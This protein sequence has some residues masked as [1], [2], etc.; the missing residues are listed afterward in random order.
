MALMVAGNALADGVMGVQVHS[1]L[2]NQMFLMAAQ[3]AYAKRLN[4]D[5][6]L[7]E[8]FNTAFRVPFRVCNAQ[9]KQ[10][11]ESHICY[12]D[13]FTPEIFDKKNCL[14]LDGGYYQDQRYFADQ[15]NIVRKIFGWANPLPDEIRG[16]ADEIQA[17]NSVSIHV[18]H[19]WDYVSIG[20]PVMSEKYYIHAV[21]YIR[22]KSEKP[23]HLYVFSDNMEWARKNLKFNYPTTFIEGNSDV[24]DMRLMSMCRHH[25][26]ANSTFSW[27]GAYLDP[28]PNKIVIAPDK[29]HHEMSWWGE[30]IIPP[31]W[32]IL[33]AQV[34]E[35]PVDKETETTPDNQDE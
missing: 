12:F 35:K 17:T 21:N 20:Y 33:A 8:P 30:D 26:I 29:W 24:T 3:V 28:N 25:I 10:N 18:R 22:R 2:G 7:I 11:A 14:M 23:L 13:R 9:E 15:E 1:G 4:K 16:L 19:G 27:W 6:C 31:N 5:I 32:I 34:D